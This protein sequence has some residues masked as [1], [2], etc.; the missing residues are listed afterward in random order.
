MVWAAVTPSA[1]P[2]STASAFPLI[3]AV[4]VVCASSGIESRRRD[5]SAR[6]R[7]QP[8]PSA[9]P[10]G[11]WARSRSSPTR[12]VAD[13]GLPHPQHPRPRQDGTAD[14]AG[15]TGAVAAHGGHRQPGGGARANVLHLKPELTQLQG[16]A[17]DWKS[18]APSREESS[19]PANI[20]NEQGRNLQGTPPLLGC[21]RCQ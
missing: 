3:R 8:A 9:S 15:A 13:D 14:R 16:C 2:T 6:C 18:S 20:A 7:W 4:Y 10:A 21:P 1:S 19:S 11:S 12:G 17:R 5:T